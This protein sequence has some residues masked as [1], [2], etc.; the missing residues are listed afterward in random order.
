MNTDAMKPKL[1]IITTTG[2]L[3]TKISIHTK[4]AW[5][6]REGKGTYTLN[7]RPTSSVYNF[8]I[9]PLLPPTP[10]ARVPA[11]RAAAA[12][13]FASAARRLYTLVT[14]LATFMI[15][16]A[17]ILSNFEKV[18]GEDSCETYR[19]SVLAPPGGGGE[20]GLAGDCGGED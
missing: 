15:K 3:H 16:L 18:K 13:F 10:A 8:N 12:L 4:P 2:S 6:E 17:G 9:V 14:I 11:G 20:L 7:P 19:I 1:K 5:P